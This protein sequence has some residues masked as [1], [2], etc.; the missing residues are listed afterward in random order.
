MVQVT[1]FIQI[2]RL[3]R[4]RSELTNTI[5]LSLGY[6]AEPG[7]SSILPTPQPSSNNASSY[8]GLNYYYRHYDYVHRPLQALR[9]LASP[10]SDGKPATIEDS[11]HYRNN[12]HYDPESKQHIK[13]QGA[14]QS[15]KLKFWTL[16]AYTTTFLF[17][18]TWLRFPQNWRISTK[19][20][21]KN[22]CR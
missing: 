3:K 15:F 22:I 2:Q 19:Q 6:G 10:D 18:K 4:L 12:E 17:R 8:T 14:P 9:P 5:L 16:R 13:T 21:H 20:N 1:K 7:A 11:C